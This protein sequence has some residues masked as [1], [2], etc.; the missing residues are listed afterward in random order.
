MDA[1][2]DFTGTWS[3]VNPNAWLYV[4]H[5]GDPFYRVRTVY[6]VNTNVP[7]LFGEFFDNTT[8]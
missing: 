8:A 4:V 5:N 2:H 1:I 3:I 7:S 6:L